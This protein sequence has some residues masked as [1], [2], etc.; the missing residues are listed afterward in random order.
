[1]KEVI[2]RVDSLSIEE[3]TVA[4]RDALI[5]CNL[6]FFTQELSLVD[7]KVLKSRVKKYL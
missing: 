1:M 5:Q 6:P 7:R 4:S 2:R 3:D